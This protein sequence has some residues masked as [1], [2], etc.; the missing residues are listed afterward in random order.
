MN[1]VGA[2]T[3]YRRVQA[4]T[5][6]MITDALDARDFKYFED[7]EGDIGGNFQGNLIYF[8]RIGQQQEVLQVRTMVQHLFGMDDVARLY[9]FCNS[10]NHDQLFPKAYVHVNDDGTVLVV[11]EVIADWERGVT[12]EQLDQV[13]IA[14]IATSVQLSNEVLELRQRG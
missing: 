8:F 2:P 12:P 10:W 9:E 7:A 14:A 11:G 6:E 1:P 3:Y 13:M 5:K 4:F